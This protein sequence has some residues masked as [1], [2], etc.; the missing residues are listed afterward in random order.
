MS[1]SYFPVQ[2][3][4]PP[5]QSGALPPGY[6]STTNPRTLAQNQRQLITQQGQQY[7][8]ADQALA[9]QY[10]GNAS[11][12]QAYLNP[13]EA[14]LATGGGGYN[15]TET[16]AI[17]YSPQDVQNI[18][19][20]AGIT[21]GANTAASVGAAERAAAAAGGSP[22]AL[23]TYRARAAQTEGN[24]GADA[25]TNAAVAAKGAESQGAQ[26]VGT[27][28]I[29]QQNEGLNYFGGLQ[30]QQT[31]TGLAEQGLGQSAYGTEAGDTN[32]AAD[33]GLKASQTPSTFDKVVGAASGAVSAL[34]DGRPGGVSDYMA[35]GRTEAV[36]GEDGPEMIV[37]GARHMDDGGSAPDG[38]DPIPLQTINPTMGTLPNAPSFR[39]F[40]G[41]FIRNYTSQP[42]TPPSA[43]PGT[44]AGGPSARQW[45]P[46]DTANSEGRIIGA[47]VKAL[48][49]YLADGMPPSQ[50]ITSPTRVK[51]AP[52]DKVVPLSF[53]AK[54]K[55][56]PSA[57]LPAIQAMQGGRR[58]MSAA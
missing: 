20:N 27:A 19:T 46:I 14:N 17:E 10:L 21:A 12:T 6:T 52:G 35:D 49:P 5:P 44:G 30:G 23:A 15:P 18:V 47:G 41:N 24:Q 31:Q 57:A 38:G 1:S 51:L 58:Q 16:A 56:R 55:I 29:G 9:N 48:A 50:L 37:S 25:M 4:N 36:A 28:R 33:I 3:Y 2:A 22:A 26:T 7:Q 13:L 40:A 53:R 11:G 54:A 34:A 39:S 32:T 42:Q 43:S 45:S 8:G